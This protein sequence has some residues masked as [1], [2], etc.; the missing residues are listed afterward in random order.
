MFTCMLEIHDDDLP[1]DTVCPAL[2]H[3]L[4][5]AQ[6]RNAPCRDPSPPGL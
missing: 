1:F 6:T 3:F 2:W 4:S 5:A